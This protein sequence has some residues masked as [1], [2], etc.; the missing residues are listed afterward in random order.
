MKTLKFK[1]VL[2]ILF[3]GLASASC[4]DDKKKETSSDPDISST[5]TPATNT[6]GDQNVPTTEQ[7]N[8][9]QLAP[10]PAGASSPDFSEAKT[11][12]ILLDCNYFSQNPNAVLKDNPDAAIDYI[13]PCIARIDGKLT[14]E[15]GVTIAFEQNAGL[16]F[17]DKSS[18]KMQGTVEKPILLTGKE[19][20]K[21]YWKGVGTG[22]NGMSNTM[23]YVTID[24]AGGSKAALEIYTENTILNLEHC[25][26]SNSKNYGMITN[27]RVGKD[28]N[29]IVMENCTF[30][31]NK[32]PFKTDVTRLR[33]FNGTNTF[34]GNENDYIEL[35]EGSLFGDATWAK[36]DVPYFLQ[37][38]LNIKEGVFTVAPG[39]EVIMSSQKWM[40]IDGNAS[41]V[42]M[43][44]ADDPITI[45]GEHDVAGFWQQ[46]NVRSS[47]PLNEIGHVIIKNAGRTTKKPNG[48]I[49][50]ESSRFL[51]IHDVV[52]SNCF[53]YGISVQ[54]AGKS[55][56]EHANLSLDNTPKLFS[57]W[58][59]KEIPA[60][61]SL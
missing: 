9:S 2:F 35:D 11:A 3:I 12:A 56:L 58:N 23:S 43:G 61:E 32:I 13:I 39:T 27:S 21:G 40:H 20:I 5:N 22:S 60:P 50:L 4:G 45:R 49:F 26:F 18:I 38:N 28:V 16:N 53:E 55:H 34:S 47:S 17:S 10:D 30:T 37:G 31:K 24:Y 15:P 59:G 33:L 8:K 51:K 25:T 6:I 48:A 41:L 46:I 29:N 52:F 14:I 1:T 36:L 44:T 54:N 7:E 57:D 19:H 42:M